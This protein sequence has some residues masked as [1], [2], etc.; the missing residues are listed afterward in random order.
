[1]IRAAEVVVSQD[2][3]QLKTLFYSRR[4]SIEEQQACFM[5]MRQDVE[6]HWETVHIAIYGVWCKYKPRLNSHHIDCRK[7]THQ[8]KAK[9]GYL[10]PRTTARPLAGT[11]CIVWR[12]QPPKA[13]PEQLGLVRIL[14]RTCRYHTWRTLQRENR[15]CYPAASPNRMTRRA[16]AV[17]LGMCPPHHKRRWRLAGTR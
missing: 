10:H 6:H 5:S 15:L 14:A 16:N 9:M 1:M 17:R 2:V 11:N 7:G 8:T 4:L 12:I 13:P 3:A